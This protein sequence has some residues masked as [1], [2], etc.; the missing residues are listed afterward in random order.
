[1][2]THFCV[3]LIYED[4]S[5]VRPNRKNIS[6]TSSLNNLSATGA[7]TSTGTASNADIS[8]IT[9]SSSGNAAHSSYESEQSR[10]KQEESER[11]AAEQL[12]LEPTAPANNG[13]SAQDTDSNPPAY[14]NLFPSLPK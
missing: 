1:V 3:H 6:A 4:P 7:Q 2:S 11:Y 12:S 9:S 13:Y 5:N 14:G 10:Q 8:S